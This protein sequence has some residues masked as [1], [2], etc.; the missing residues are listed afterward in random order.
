M[1]SYEYD[2]KKTL[3]KLS[4]NH[5]ALEDRYCGIIKKMIWADGNVQWNPIALTS[6][7]PPY[8][9]H[10][11]CSVN[12]IESFD[13]RD[14]SIL[15]MVKWYCDG[16]WH[17]DSLVSIAK[18]YLTFM[19]S[20]AWANVSEKLNVIESEYRDEVLVRDEIDL[21][22]ELGFGSFV[23]SEYILIDKISDH[24]YATIDYFYDAE[25]F[26]CY[27]VEVRGIYI[28]SCYT[29]ESAQRMAL[30]YL[31]YNN[32]LRNAAIRMLPINI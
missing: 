12:G 22:W 23:Q 4:W 5:P 16:Y 20:P 9:D 26:P 2:H 11:V 21:K 18:E 15:E 31:A 14:C 17:R 28:G 13:S 19:Q 30:E 24:I 25:G 6:D 1:F 3:W 7:K 29:V 27:R 8:R 32:K 10:I